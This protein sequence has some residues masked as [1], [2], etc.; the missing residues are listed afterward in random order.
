MEEIK[1]KRGRPRKTA[2][3]EEIQELVDKVQ[4][5]QQ[6]LQKE[7]IVLD[8]VPR[9]G[10][11]WDVK[12][13]DSIEHFDK[14][15]SYELTGYRPIN[16]TQGLDFNP[17]WFTEARDTFLK[18][19][20]YCSYFQGSKAYR[21]FWNIEYKRCREGLT[22]NGYTIP[23][24]YYYFL[25][26]YQ[27]PQTESDKAGQSRSDIFPNFYVYQ[28]EFFHY[29]ELC[30]HL[31]K[32]LCLMKA[33]GIGFSEVNAAICDA[34]YNCFP[35]SICMIT[36][37][38]KNHLDQTLNKV[39]G[40]MT[41]AN[42]NTDGGF[43]KLRQVLDK[44]DVK[45]ASYYKIVNGQKIEAGWN[46]EI[47][48]LVADDDAKIRGARVDL[49]VFEEAGS[50]P[51]ARRSFIKGE[52]LV[53]I[54][55]NRFGVRLIGGTGGDRNPKALDGLREIY[56][57]PRAFNVLPFYHNYT[58]SGDWVE[59]GYFI[60]SYIAKYKSSLVDS[61]GV[62]NWKKAK[63]EEQQQR[64]L[65]IN[66]PQGLLEHKAEFC[67]TAQEA[68][69][70]EGSNKFNKVKIT[71]QQIAIK[72]KKES[73]EII[74]GFMEFIYSGPNRKREDITGVR[75][76][77][78]P[79]GPV[80]ILQEPVWQDSKDKINNLYVAGID[81]V[82]IGMAETS[83]ETR[84][85]SKFCTVI[86]KRVYG[87][88]EPT[89]VAYYLD[90]PN[91]IREAYK[92][93]IGLLMYYQAQANIEA[94]RISLLT[95]ARDNKFMQFFM[96]RPRVCFGD[97]MKRRS[98]NQYGTTA[99]KAMIEHQTD[100][101]ADYVE[102]YCHNIWFPEFLEQLSA[103]SDENKGKFDIVAALGMAEIA[104]EELND[105]LPRE[106]KI[107]KD[108]FQDI[109]YYKDE[110]GYTRFGV[111]PKRTQPTI[112]ATWSLYDNRNVTSNPYY[113]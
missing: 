87:M 14:R 21:D 88:S 33:R 39:W 93:T 112:E 56:E 38:S 101:I 23:G 8:K 70:L 102:D 100:L 65:L 76:K 46:S 71:E 108:S 58:E 20:H 32:D 35:G 90:R 9:E 98:A 91:D 30:Q 68:F 75:F 36:A 69:A 5:K 37:P 34:L 73:P 24:T 92:Q 62:C 10:I 11:E 45:R 60:P 15:L 104:D 2:L 78:N 105:V 77:P 111:I 80:H 67:W 28:Y 6:Q 63:Q 47:K 51:N 53:G 74:R 107:I 19:G 12:I 26:Y 50:N 40:G 84:D 13:G 113:R 81:G 49:L 42:D 52:A 29:Y 86:K 109:G 61:R 72:I 66:N 22:V 44:A 59:T 4:E 54:G 82:D 43:F 79:N 41:F 106:Q 103:Y 85:P 110:R 31:K 94:T 25:N 89:Y 97:T 99:T 55:G 17:K 83:V 48:G 7:E 3:P 57:D 95:Y 18:T 96:R 27:L 1:R 16:E 64:D